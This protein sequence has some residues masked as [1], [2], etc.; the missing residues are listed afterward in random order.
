M[1]KTADKVRNKKSVPPAPVR[2]RKRLSREER[3]ADVR[4]AIFDAAT[5]VIRQHGYAGASISRITEAA[6]FAQ[7]TFYL[8]FGSRQELFDELLPHAG[9]AML[10]FIRERV[11]GSRDIYDMEERGFRA[12]FEYLDANPGFIRVLNEAETA[13]PLAHRKHFKILADRYLVALERAVKRGEIRNFDR[14]ELETVAYMMMAARSYLYLRYVKGN[15]RHR[16]LPEKVV[17]A[18]MKIIRGGLS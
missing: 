12:F 5:R 16:K 7:G 14:D 10:D 9:V 17:K 11:R 1:R 2:P 4:E 3:S 8:Y 6:G 18:Y 13:A 15:E